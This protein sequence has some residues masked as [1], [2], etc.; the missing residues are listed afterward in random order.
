MAVVESNGSEP[1]ATEALRERLE[2]ACLNASEPMRHHDG[3]VR[4]MPIG[5]VYPRLQVVPRSRRNTH[6]GAEN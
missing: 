2:A 6:S 4:A 1:F 3:R 5:L